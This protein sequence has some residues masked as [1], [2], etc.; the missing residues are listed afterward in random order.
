L[1]SAVLKPIAYVSNGKLIARSEPTSFHALTVDS[2][3]IGTS[4]V[5][6]DKLVLVLGHATMVSRDTQRI[7]PDVAQGMA[8]DDHHGTIQGDVRTFIQGNQACGH[9]GASCPESSLPTPVKR[10]R[11]GLL[12]LNYNT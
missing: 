4:Q 11:R 2:N 12:H 5:A 9:E 7:E 1:S 10:N 3:P 8:A 6:D